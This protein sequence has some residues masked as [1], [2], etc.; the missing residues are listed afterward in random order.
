MAL[1]RGVG[2]AVFVCLAELLPLGAAPLTVRL[3]TSE[4]QPYIREDREA[5]GYVYEL[6][7]EAFHAAGCEVDIQFRPW[8]RALAE[9]EAGQ[10]DGLFLEYYSEGRKARFVYSHPFP[11]GPV[12]FLA[13]KADAITFPVDPRKDLAGALAG[14]RQYRFGVVRGYINIKG[15][16]EAPGLM[17]DEATSDLQNIQKLAT[18]RV[19][20]VFID[21]YVAG[22]LIRKDLAQYEDSL[23]FLEPALEKK[24]L[25]IAFSR[26]APD[27]GRKLEAF[28]TGLAR[29]RQTGTLA[30]ILKKYG[31]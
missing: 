17:R 27:L 26:R 18:G 30:A 3:S 22:Y 2:T 1:L 16:D 4:W 31:F 8:A 5:P 14:L 11:G 6:V 19:D 10:A 21:Q 24:D 13:R 12:G 25:F 23:V 9:A 28:N 15:L 29:L 20:L 7:K